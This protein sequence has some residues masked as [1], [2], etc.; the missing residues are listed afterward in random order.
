MFTAEKHPLRQRPSQTGPVR[1]S[2]P[3]VIAALALSAIGCADNRDAEEPSDRP[4]NFVLVFTDDLGY[5]DLGAYGHPTI[6]T[7]VLDRLAAE[8]QK[9]TNF[10]A[11]AAVCSPSRAGVLTGRLGIRSGVAGEDVSKHVFF[12]NSLGG[13]PPE[14][15]TIAEIL[16]NKGYISTAIGKWH[17]GHLPE[18]LP[19]KQGFESYFGIPYSNDMNM[20]GGIEEPWSLEL[21]HRE[22]NI[23]YWDVPLMD[24]DEIIERPADQRTITERYTERAVRFIEENQETPFFLYLAHNMPHTPVFASQD[25][26][27][28]SERGLYGDV[29]AEIDWSV[30]E[31]VRTL[32]KLGIDDDTLVIFTSDNGPWL[33]MKQLGGSA[34]LLRD[35][36]GTTWEGGMREPAIFYWP[37]TVEPAVVTG[38]GS[39]LDFLPTLAALAGA[40]LPEDRDYDG[41]DL[42]KSLLSGAESPRDH[43]FFWRLQDVFAVRK[44]PY[45]AHFTTMNSFSEQGPEQH[46]EPLLF[47]VEVDPSEQF[48]IAAQHPEVVAELSRLAADHKSAITPVVDQLKLYPPGEAPGESE[49]T[50][51][52]PSDQF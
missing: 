17:L 14:E 42:S 5:G 43:V 29:L 20:P 35:G 34:G 48:D 39:G 50:G 2:A 18:F 7:P 13:L 3:F 23:N 52:R 21:F 11:P 6:R 40:D 9:W 1:W 16:S 44:G 33:S 22:P 28:S 38:I 30:G 24:H 8:G 4:P 41:V 27:G 46:P 19:T 12:P 37:G 10:Y 49:S 32:E 47:N 25:F 26:Q 15:I 31:V 51:K 36:K 45:K